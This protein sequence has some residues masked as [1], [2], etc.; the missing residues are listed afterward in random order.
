MPKLLTYLKW[1]P[2]FKWY[3][4][5]GGSK[6]SYKKD[7]CGKEVGIHAQNTMSIL[8]PIVHIIFLEGEGPI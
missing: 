1:T 3:V 4:V 8:N 5:R 2:I 6:S 7:M